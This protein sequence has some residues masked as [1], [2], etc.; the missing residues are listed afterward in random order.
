MELFRR[1]L[2]DCVRAPL[3]RAD[4]YFMKIRAGYEISYDCPQPT[5]MILQ[6]SVHPSRIP[7][8]HHLGRLQIDPP[9][10]ANT[11]HDT[12]GNFCHVIR[13]PAGRL[14]MSTDFLVQDSGEPDAVAPDARQHPLEDLPVEA[15][16]FSSAAATAR[17]IGCRI[18]PGRCSAIC[19]KAGRWCRRSATTRTIASSSATSTR[20]RPRRR[21]TPIPSGA[22]CAATSPISRSRCAAA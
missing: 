14:T 13:A 12:F 9:I 2:L 8:L 1:G 22:A 11:Y 19:R 18:S 10:P 3:A 21:S 15:L 16:I 17:P 4:R 5:P 7:D 6:V 20:A